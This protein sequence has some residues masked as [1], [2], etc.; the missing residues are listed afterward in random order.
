MLDAGIERRLVHQIALGERHD[1]PL[2]AQHVDDLEVLLG[3]RLPSLVGGDHEQHQSNRTHAGQH[4]PDEALVPGHVDEPDLPARWQGGPGEPEVDGEPAP[5]L[6]RQPVGIHAGEPKDQG[7]LAVIDVPG[8]RH[9]VRRGLRG[10]HPCSR[11]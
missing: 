6:L 3:L 9:D 2:R 5:F 4:V 1:G 10:V 7:R 8:R 11:A